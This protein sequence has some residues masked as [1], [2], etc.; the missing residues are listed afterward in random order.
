MAHGRMGLSLALVSALAGSA[1]AGGV[2]TSTTTI[3]TTTTIASTTTT[4]TSLPPACTDEVS[5]DSANCRLDELAAAVAGEPALGG[6]GA[7]LGVALNKADS[8]VNLGNEQCD[9]GD[10]K[11]AGKRLK[12]AIRRMIQY[13]HRLRSLK[14]RKT[15]PEEVR[16]PLVDEGAAIQQDLE[17]LRKQLVCP[18]ASPSG[19]F[20]S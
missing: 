11:T 2:S 7:K 9:A 5:F 19:A 14:A 10:A 20:V 8:S 12:K 18:P 15:V 16:T 6:L 1:L 4:S 13:G 17:A 3:I